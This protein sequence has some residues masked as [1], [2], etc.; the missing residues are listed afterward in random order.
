M[1]ARIGITTSYKDGTQSINQCYIHAIENAGGIPLIV[2]MLQTDEATEAF[3]SLLDGLV[4]I[5]GLGITRGLQGDL[6]DD[7]PPVDAVHDSS[8]ERI[9]KAF[10]KRP[11]LGICYGMQ[12]INAM[13]GGSIYGDLNNSIEAP[14]NHSASRGATSHPIRI[15]PDTHLY[16][17]MQ[18][19]SLDVNTY[20]IQAL[21]SVGEGLRVSATAADGII[22][23]IESLDGRIIGLQFH[24]E[25]MG[26]TMQPLFDDFVARCRK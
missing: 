16:R 2:P 7:L 4:I 13:R 14:L 15:Q 25:R 19:E 17:I 23:G 9:Y 20:H 5:G 18:C 10:T 8:D 24:P 21:A 3:A 6:P 12:F 26:A 11:I 1:Q 22:E